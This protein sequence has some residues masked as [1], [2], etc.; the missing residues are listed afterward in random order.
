MSKRI[1]KNKFCPRCESSIERM[2]DEASVVYQCSGCYFTAASL[3]ELRSFP[4]DEYW[5]KIVL[6]FEA[7]AGFLP[8]LGLTDFQI[9][10]VDCFLCGNAIKRSFQIQNKKLDLTVSIGI[11]CFNNMLSM[12]E[13]MDVSLKCTA[14]QAA[15]IQSKTGVKLD[16]SIHIV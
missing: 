16:T 11:N 15:A 8:D 13:R 4:D 2:A 12:L 1:L 3:G 6:A 14:A 5:K 9:G 10:S 7:F